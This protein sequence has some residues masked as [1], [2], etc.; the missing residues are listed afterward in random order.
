LQEF[1]SHF[2]RRPRKSGLECGDNDDDDGENDLDQERSP[3]LE[4][5][6]VEIE[7]DKHYLHASSLCLESSLFHF[8]YLPIALVRVVVV[9]LDLS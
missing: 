4:H 2:E 3:Q 6:F 9:V 7:R 8:Y 1:R 5:R